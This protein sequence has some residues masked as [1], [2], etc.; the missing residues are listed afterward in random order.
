MTAAGR[1]LV[2]M[3]H[4]DDAEI[5]AG[6]TL[7]RLRDEGWAVG[8]VSMTSGDCGST[9]E[10]TNEEIARIR[11][12]EAERAA[13]S[14]GAWYG[15][16][17]LSD[18]EVFANA[19]S[20]RTTVELLRTFDPD[21]VMTHAPVDYMLDHEETT[22][23]VRAAVFAAGAPLYRTRREPAA[24]AA[25]RTAALYYADPV[26]GV[27]HAGR[28]VVPDFHVDISDVIEQ[29]RTLVSHHASQREWLRAHH[30]MDEYLDSM[31]AWAAAAGRECGVA[32]AEGFRQHRGHGYPR[33]PRLQE[34]LRAHIRARL[35]NSQ[36]P[37]PNFH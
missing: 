6:G 34:A 32:Y 27:D 8:I 17:G 21:V 10:R 19:E 36:L 13:G 23:I 4:P 3:S 20:V 26:E 22:R 2:V 9:A 12:E 35:V 15:C 24:A 37:T 29:K 18:I 1:A 28:R 30:G 7:L 14:I 16:A 31:T 11:R 5:L 33:E 25:R